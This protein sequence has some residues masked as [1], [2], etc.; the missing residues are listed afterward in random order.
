MLCVYICRVNKD[1][2]VNNMC[3]YIKLIK[4]CGGIQKI[5]TNLSQIIYYTEYE[6]TMRLA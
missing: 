1:Y 4:V 5:G 3:K 2:H 6:N